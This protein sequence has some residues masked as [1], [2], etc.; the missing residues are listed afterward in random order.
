M[1]YDLLV[2]MKILNLFQ[3][4]NKPGPKKKA[5]IAEAIEISDV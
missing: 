1:K 2:V 3:N 5:A 4:Q